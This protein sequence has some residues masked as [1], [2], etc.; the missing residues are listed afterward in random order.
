MKIYIYIYILL[1]LKIKKKKKKK[2]IPFQKLR[3]IFIKY[4]Y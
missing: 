2:K 1:K 4:M 3:K